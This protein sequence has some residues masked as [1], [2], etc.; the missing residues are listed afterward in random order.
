MQTSKTTITVSRQEKSLAGTKHIL[1]LALGMWFMNFS[2]GAEFL[3]FNYY[4][5]KCL[6]KASG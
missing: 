2:L 5:C 3:H 1:I 4:K 6:Y